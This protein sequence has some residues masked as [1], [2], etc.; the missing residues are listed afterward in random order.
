MT[1]HQGASS[2]R[3]EVAQVIPEAN[4]WASG[5]SEPGGMHKQSAFAGMTLAPQDLQ[6]RSL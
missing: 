1:S 4:S 3:A 6:Q 2:R 5:S